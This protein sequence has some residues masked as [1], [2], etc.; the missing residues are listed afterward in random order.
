M[1]EFE[2][3]TVNAVNTNPCKYCVVGHSELC[4]IAGICDACMDSKY[5][6]FKLAKS[7]VYIE[8]QEI[9]PKF[10]FVFGRK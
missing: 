7:Y 5:N 4:D 2:F 9:K 8:E 10:V 1:N 3:V 6:S